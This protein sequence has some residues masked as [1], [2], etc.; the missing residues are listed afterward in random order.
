MPFVQVSLKQ[1]KTANE[2]KAISDSIHESL[3]TIFGIPTDDKFQVFHEV[4]LENIIFPTSY[5]QIPHS[6]NLIYIHITAKKGR[7]NT[8]K[9][10]LY[11]SIVTLIHQ[12][13]G[14]NPD[15]IMII[16]SENDEANWSFGR[17]KAQLI[18]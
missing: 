6:E 4:P 17:G 10:A 2:K 16:I 14:H 9:K 12:R 5:M 11:A 18:D 1:G 3:I 7:T 15:D 13:I 8:M